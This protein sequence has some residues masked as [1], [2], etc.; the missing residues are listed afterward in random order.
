MIKDIN[1]DGWN[2]AKIIC[3]NEDGTVLCD[4]YL[5][6]GEKLLAFESGIS[7]NPDNL[8]FELSES[9]IEEIKNPKENEDEVF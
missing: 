5:M 3:I 6:D 1:F 9:E 4:L 8:P 7:F 2:R